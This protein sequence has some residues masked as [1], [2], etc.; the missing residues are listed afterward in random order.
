[1]SQCAQVLSAAGIIEPIASCDFLPLPDYSV[2]IVAILNGRYVLRASVGDGAARLAHEQQA[3]ETLQAFAGIPQVRGAGRLDLGGEAYFLLEDKI[4]GRTVFPLWLEIDDEA[5]GGLI[6]EL[7]T[8]LR[9]I[10]QVP[11]RSY[12]IGHHQDALREWCG[13]W[14]DGHDAYMRQLLAR[15]RARALTADQADLVDAAEAYYVANRTALAHGVGPRFA[16]GDLHLYNVLAEDG[17]VTGVIDWEWAYGGGTEPDFDLDALIRWAIYP[18]G[19]AEEALE[20]RVTGEDFARLIPALLAAYPEIGAIPRLCERMTIY[21]IEHELH[22]MAS[23]PPRV[24][25]EPVRRL[26]AWVRERRLAEYLA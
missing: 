11:R 16:H 25:Q 12:I 4:P 1:M 18:R 13:T 17:H 7:V 15:V 3:L 10:H 2:N 9:P 8:I 5:R 21:Q 6:T 26:H 20:E 24:P 23:W 19:I 14:L 22:K